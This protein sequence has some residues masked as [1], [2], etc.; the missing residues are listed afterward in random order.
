MVSDHQPF[1]KGPRSGQGTPRSKGRAPPACRFRGPFRSDLSLDASALQTSFAEAG[2]RSC[3][4]NRY[5]LGRHNPLVSSAAASTTLL[6]VSVA[7]LIMLEYSLPVSSAAL[8]QNSE[9][10]ARISSGVRL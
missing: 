4:A 2:A 8:D 7:I 10:V 5:A 3:G 6:V 9:Y 1:Q